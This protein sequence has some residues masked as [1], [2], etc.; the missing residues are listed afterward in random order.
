MTPSDKPLLAVDLEAIRD[1]LPWLKPE[2]PINSQSAAKAVEL[3]ARC[4]AT[5]GFSPAEYSARLMQM[6]EEMAH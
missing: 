1:A 5:V 2:T 3:V 4:S 6:V